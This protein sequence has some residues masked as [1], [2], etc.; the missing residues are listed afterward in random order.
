M[1]QMWPLEMKLYKYKVR[2]SEN[3]RANND[4]RNLDLLLRK[5]DKKSISPLE[6]M[7]HML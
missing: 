2:M 6:E 4:L 1:L 5:V 3:K 7:C